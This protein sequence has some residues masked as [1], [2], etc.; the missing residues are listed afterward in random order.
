M[1]VKAY[2]NLSL[3]I[4]MSLHLIQLMKTKSKNVSVKRYRKRFAWNYEETLEELLTFFDEQ[5]II[6]ALTNI[7]SKSV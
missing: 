2:E 4:K 5:A 6:N 1:D 7:T 3:L